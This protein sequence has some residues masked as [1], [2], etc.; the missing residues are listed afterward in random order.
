MNEA[1]VR[2]IFQSSW[3]N[4]I[5]DNN[6]IY[7]CSL[8]FFSWDPSDREISLDGS[9]TADELEAIVWWMRNKVEEIDQSDR[10]QMRKNPTK[11]DVLSPPI[12]KIAK[13]S[14]LKGIAPNITGG[15][16]SEE[17]IRKLRDLDG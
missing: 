17:Y 3:G 10:E 13:L 4:V 11:G 5:S 14:E 8:S 15:L 12:D 6:G 16:S 1:K 9:F 7:L 2:E